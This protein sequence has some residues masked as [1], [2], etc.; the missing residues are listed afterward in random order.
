MNAAAGDDVVQAGAGSDTVVSTSGTD[1]ILGQAGNDVFLFDAT[2]FSANTST[3]DG[4]AGIDIVR[5]IDTTITVSDGDFGNNITNVERLEIVAS[6]A[7]SVILGANFAR[8]Q[9]LVTQAGIVTSAQSAVGVSIDASNVRAAYGISFTLGDNADT[10]IGSNGADTIYAGSGADRIDARLGDDVLSLTGAQALAIVTSNATLSGGAG[11]DTLLITTQAS[12]DDALLGQIEKFETISYAST[13]GTLALVLGPLAS[14]TGKWGHDAIGN[15]IA[16]NGH[17]ASGSASLQINAT[18]LTNGRKILVDATDNGD[19]ILGSANHDIVRGHGG[20]D[21]IQGGVGIDDITA[22]S[23]AD[24]L[25]LAVGDS[26]NTMRDRVRDFDLVHDRVVLLGRNSFL[27]GDIDLSKPVTTDTHGLW[28]IA[29]GSGYAMQLEGLALANIG[30]RIQ[31]GTAAQAY[32]TGFGNRNVIGGAFADHIV[33]NLGDDTLQ[34][35]GGADTLT[36]GIGTDKF[37]Y[38]NAQVTDS[39]LANADVISDFAS[40]TDKL[41]IHLDYTSQSLGQNIQIGTLGSAL[42]GTVQGQT[43]FAN[44]QLQVNIDGDSDIDDN[45]LVVNIAGGLTGSDIVYRLTGTAHADTLQ[46]GDGGD[47]LTGGA[48]NDRLL[49]SAGHDVMQGGEGN[50]YFVYTTVQ[51]ANL[52]QAGTIDGGAGNDQIVLSGTGSIDDNDFTSNVRNIETVRFAGA[53]NETLVLRLG[54]KADDALGSAVQNTV[55][56]DASSAP[57]SAKSGGVFVLARDF[58]NA[59]N[60]QILATQVLDSIEGGWGNDTVLG[61]EGNDTIKGFAGA[62]DLRGGAG[63]DDLQGGD[64]NDILQGGAGVDRLQGGAGRDLFVYSTA[65]VAHSSG[66][67]LITHDTI[68]DFVSGDDRLSIHFDY[69]ASSSAINLQLA[70]IVSAQSGTRLGQM[71]YTGTGTSGVFA[72][73]VDGDHDIDQHDLQIALKA[74]T[75]FTLRDQDLAIKITGGSADDAIQAGP[76]SAAI[77]GGAGDDTLA[78]GVGNDTLSG[79]GGA[80]QL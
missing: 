59:R 48:G 47:T 72:L 61:Y 25:L 24:Q 20:D 56:I 68:S 74:V 43:I 5:I 13:A 70:G 40:G 4:G 80:D 37:V 60:L 6:Q 73:N 54:A 69:A 49:A 26:T 27:Q 42:Q 71:I 12:L 31:L 58:A 45:D 17:G 33:G 2:K 32:Q 75:P 76:A 10:L 16:I 22:G 23:G 50:D 35:G 7:A 77:D 65:N 21:T 15:S 79:G 1:R 55:N 62:D 44:H 39:N 28:T 38:S 64:G 51:F 63:A 57:G 46:G 52:S 34:G 14:A 41:Q 36:G 78:G 3:W 8:S 53:L 9:N 11:Q 19:R 29:D 67:S 66:A 30:A 18:A